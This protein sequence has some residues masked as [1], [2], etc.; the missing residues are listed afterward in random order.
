[1]LLAN[2][3]LLA[4]AAAAVMLGTLYPLFLDAL[5]LGKISVGPPYFDTV[6]L[7]LM[8]PAIFLMAVGPV[9]SWKRATLPG[10]WVRLRWALAVAVVAALLLPLLLGRWSLLTAFGLWLGLWVVAATVAQLVQRLKIAPQRTLAARLSAQ[11]LAW[12][13]M[14]LAHLGVAVFVFGVT[15]VKSYEMERDL[16]MA[17]GEH[18]T[19]GGYEFT[20]KGTHQ[21]PGPNYAST[22]GEFEVR[23]AGSS[24]VVRTLRPE[25][26]LYQAT[27]QTMTE[28]AID[29]GFSRDLYVLLGEP[30]AEAAW[31]VRIYFKPFV[32]WIWGGCFLMALGGIL[33]LCDRRYRSHRLAGDAALHRNLSPARP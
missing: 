12:Y 17:P 6:F 15:L 7:P 26:R 16:R 29:S 9:A 31:G 4:I 28:A 21:V 22:E 11:P 2:N 30:V 32:N 24:E 18:V 23:R 20:F 33:A 27:G 1:M 8:A 5:D 3:V 10:L 25:K 13:G 19:L 14:T